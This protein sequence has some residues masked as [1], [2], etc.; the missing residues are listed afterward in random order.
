MLHGNFYIYIILIAFT[1]YNI[2]IQRI[3]SLI[4]VGYELLNTAFII[5]RHLISVLSSIINK[6]NS[7]S[8]RKKCCLTKSGLKSIKIKCGCLKYCIIRE[9]CNPCSCTFKFAGTNFFQRIHSLTALIALLIS[10][11]LTIDFNLKPVRQGIYNRSSNT[12]KT[13]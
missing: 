12:M 2:R 3:I 7:Q 13:T 11:A 6:G 9:E 5:V 10:L 1:I 8:F 4:Q